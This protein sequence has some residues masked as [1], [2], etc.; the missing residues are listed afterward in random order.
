[1]IWP[2][3]RR[4]KQMTESEQHPRT[5]YS[6][7]TISASLKD[8]D[9]LRRRPAGDRKL[10]YL[11]QSTLSSLALDDD[12]SELMKFLD[13]AVRTE[14]IVCLGAPEH[15]DES[16]VAPDRDAIQKVR[17][18]LSMGIGFLGWQEI[19]WKEVRAIAGEFVAGA[20]VVPDWREAFRKDPQTPRGKLYPGGMQVSVDMGVPD[21][22]VD[23]VAKQKELEL[24]LDKPYEVDRAKGWSFETLAAA[25]FNDMVNIHLR[26][27]FD[28]KTYS[29]MFLDLGDQVFE[30]D[31]T[32]VTDEDM[33][34]IHRLMDL[35]EMRRN[36]DYLFE[37]YPG[38]ANDIMGFK[39][40]LTRSPMIAFP[41]LLRSGIVA[42]PRRKAKRGDGFDIKHLT[43]AL[44]RCDFVTCDAGMAQLCKNFKLVPA[45]C[46][47]FS[48]R[49]QQALVAAIADAVM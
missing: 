9:A 27:L 12:H 13:Q 44:S 24:T 33:N 25:F 48:Y 11:D 38:I 35:Q 5:E 20:P 17:R 10:V 41:A 16:L 45:G 46:Q 21:W 6:T 36:V 15:E 42:T 14:R 4:K 28:W 49:E 31:P 34:K 23:S 1:M 47:V 22:R 29:D 32:V 26:P 37:S 18:T 30:G 40:A 39:L 7:Q 2:C 43:N 19:L 3:K 8:I